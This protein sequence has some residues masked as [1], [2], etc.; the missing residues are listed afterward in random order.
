[1]RQIELTKGYYAE[2]DDADYVWLMQWKWCAC[3]NQS[4]IIYAVRG[5][6]TNGK[7]RLTY[8]HRAILGVKKQRIDHKDNNGLNNQRNNLRIATRAQNMANSRSYRNCAIGYRGVYRPADRAKYRARI[9]IGG[10]D[11]HIGSFEFVEDA[12]RAYD[13][14]AFKAF[15]EFAKLNF[16][17]SDETGSARKIGARPHP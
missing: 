13:A 2:V 4:T 5:I 12:A 15:G 10:K 7:T 17:G 14:V 1:M 11:V 3:V 16:G 9:T 8:M 6:R